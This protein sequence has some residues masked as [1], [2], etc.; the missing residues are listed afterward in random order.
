MYY[1]IHQRFAIVIYLRVTTATKTTLFL[2][3]LTLT[4]E[5]TCLYWR[6]HL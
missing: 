1:Q 5:H 2:Q 6:M 3:W 4:F